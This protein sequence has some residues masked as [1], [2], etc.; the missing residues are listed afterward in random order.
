MTWHERFLGS[1]I[2]HLLKAS[3]PITSELL[4]PNL[5]QKISEQHKISEVA[6]KLHLKRCGRG[7]HSHFSRS[8]SHRGNFH[9]GRGHA[10]HKSQ[11]ITT[12]PLKNVAIQETLNVSFVVEVE[13][14]NLYYVSQTWW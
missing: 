14:I 10:D 5:D 13:E 4:G 8:D 9:R 6:K 11:K 12:V 3:N 2:S 7:N 1:P